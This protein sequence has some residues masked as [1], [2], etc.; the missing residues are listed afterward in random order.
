MRGEGLK[1]RVLKG[2]VWLGIGGGSENLLRL[3]RNIILARIIAPDMF[4]KMAIVL[5]VINGFESF[6]Q[7][8]LR[9]AVV[10]NKKS[11]DSRF[12]NSVWFISLSRSVLLFILG[13]SIIFWILRFYNAIDLLFIMRIA[14][15]SIIINGL[16]SPNAYLALKRMQYDKW[17]LINRGGAFL[18]I[19]ATVVLTYLYA[20][21]WALVFGFLIEAVVRTILSYVVCPFYPKWQ[22]ERSDVKDLTH[23]A[24]GMFGVPV[25]Y[26]LYMNSDIIFIGKLCTS[27]DLGLYSMVASLAQSPAMLITLMINPI[28]MPVFSKYQTDHRKIENIIIKMNKVFSIIGYP[29]LVFVVFYSKDLLHIVYGKQY[30][31]AAIPFSILFLTTFI[32]TCSTPISTVYLSIGKPELHRLFTGIR[33]LVFLG[34]LYP[35]IIQFGLLGAALSSLISMLV[36]YVFQAY[37]AQNLLGLSVWKYVKSFSNGIFLPA[38][39]AITWIS[40]SLLLN[41]LPIINLTI[42]VFVCACTLLYSTLYELPKHISNNNI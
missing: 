27:E 3:I 16:F 6:T 35:F 19:G 17:T 33:A 29:M 5:T 31:S 24:K 39:I 13:Q 18:G 23:Y 11:N 30:T 4:G 21:L 25:L 38:P 42:G 28:L 14:L 9:E 22:I 20:N 1:A 2:G 36:A 26:Y 37:R 12:L 15:F 7:I 34:L 40:T 32:R 41:T 10:Q 8:G